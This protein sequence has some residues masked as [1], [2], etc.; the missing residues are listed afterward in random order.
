MNDLGTVISRYRDTLSAYC[1]NQYV[2]IAVDPYGRIVFTHEESSVSGSGLYSSVRIGDGTDLLDVINYGDTVSG[3]TGLIVYGEDESGNAYPIPIDN[4]RVKVV[5]PDQPIGVSGTI[6]VDFTPG[7]EG[8]T[9]SDEAG[10]NTEPGVVDSV[11]T[12]T[13]VDVVSVPVGAGTTY[14]L[15]GV[16]YTADRTSQF[17]LIVEDNGTPAEYIGNWIATQNV[18]SYDMQLQRAREIAGAANRIIKLQAIR[19][20]ACT[21]DA[22]VS[23]RINGYTE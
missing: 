1:D 9:H 22:N 7:T 12:S 16:H 14:N 20:A 19:L 21:V 23:G 15:L 3:N 2:P 13:W 6:N 11:G 17:R 18:A 4:D 8:D 5:L 10:A